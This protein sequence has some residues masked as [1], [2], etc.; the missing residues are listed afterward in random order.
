MMTKGWISRHFFL[1]ALTSGYEM[2]PSAIPVE[3]LDVKGIAKMTRKAG[4]ASS[5]SF[6]R[7]FDTAPIIRLPTIIRAGDVIA[8]TSDKTLTSGLKNMETANITAIVSAVR[9]VLPPAATPAEDSTNAV[10]GLVPKMLPTVVA[11]ESAKSAL[12][13]FGS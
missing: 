2:K 1:A 10:V 7:I 8:D 6:Q 3:I 5:S 11:V 13:A 4:N 9:P 12:L